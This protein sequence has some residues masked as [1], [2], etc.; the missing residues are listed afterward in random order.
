MKLNR[1]LPYT[2]SVFI[3]AVGLFFITTGY[4]GPIYL[5]LEQPGSYYLLGLSIFFVFSGILTAFLAYRGTLESTGLTIEDIRQ[6]TISKHKSK[7]FLAKIALEDENEEI[8]A[9]AAARLKEIEG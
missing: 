1:T 9:A 3:A 5:E 7:R 6:E 8:R 4:V 2:V